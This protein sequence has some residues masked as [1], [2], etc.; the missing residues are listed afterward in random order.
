MASIHREILIDAPAEAVWEAARDVG[1]LHT[2]LV[3]G[4]VT[5]TALL[6]GQGPVVRR[7]TFASGAVVDE[8]IVD[9]DDEARRLVWTIKGGGV[10][11]HNGALQVFEA[12]GGG[13]RA[14][15]IADVLPD[16]LADVFGPSMAAGLQAMKRGFE[17]G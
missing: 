9:L 7:V 17:A 16:R 8:T 2:R 14:V 1:A 12:E 4:F 6:P 5:D 11:H 13:A 10:D 15:W 3:P